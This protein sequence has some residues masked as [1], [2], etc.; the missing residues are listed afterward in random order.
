MDPTKREL[1]RLGSEIEAPPVP[2]YLAPIFRSIFTILKNLHR[3]IEQL[4]RSTR[5]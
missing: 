4:E 5:D 2:H 1:E 3:R